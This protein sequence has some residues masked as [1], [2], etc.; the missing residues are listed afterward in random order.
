LF[1]YKFIG[2]L[3]VWG[4]NIVPSILSRSIGGCLIFVVEMPSLILRDSMMA[5]ENPAT[6]QSR[7]CNRGLKRGGG[8]YL[9]SQIVYRELRKGVNDGFGYGP[10]NIRVPEKVKPLKPTLSS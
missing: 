3:S 6:V 5:K 8:Y 10:N 4:G 7:G 1:P 2:S 9:P